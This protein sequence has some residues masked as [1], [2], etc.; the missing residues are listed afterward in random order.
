MATIE[1]KIKALETKLKQE[2]AK[3]QKIESMKRAAET[4]AQRSKDTRKK[5]LLGAFL[6]ERMEKSPEYAAKVMPGL[7]EFLKRDDDRAI[8]GFSPLPK[9]PVQAS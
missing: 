7:G 3:K 8:F 5:I 6:M 9:A 1:E 2:K 4:K